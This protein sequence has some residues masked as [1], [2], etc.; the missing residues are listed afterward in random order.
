M[1]R[2]M[3]TC[4]TKYSRDALA[5]YESA[6]QLVDHPSEHTYKNCLRNQLKM[7]ILD[8]GMFEDIKTP[9]RYATRDERP[10]IPTPQKMKEL[11][12][13]LVKTLGLTVLYPEDYANSNP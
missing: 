9:G 6:Y 2:T 8:L 7:G 13:D 11:L 12:P 5:Y 4:T 10:F 3:S 1:L